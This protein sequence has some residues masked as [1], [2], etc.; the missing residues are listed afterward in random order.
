MFHYQNNEVEALAEFPCSLI[1][2]MS[3]KEPWHCGFQ[4]SAS[5]V[6]TPAIGFHCAKRS[7]ID[8][9]IP[10][11]NKGSSKQ[12]DNRVCTFPYRLVY[13]RLEKFLNNNY[14]RLKNERVTIITS[15]TCPPGYCRQDME[16]RC[17]CLTCLVFC[18]HPPVN[19]FEPHQKAAQLGGTLEARCKSQLGLFAATRRH[20]E[21]IIWRRKS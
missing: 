18:G 13:H 3:L 7:A 19:E 10:P 1:V 2:R 9:K 5:T 21:T 4:Q 6:S 14:W 8:V 12:S 11:G 15:L 16:L 20:L 17:S